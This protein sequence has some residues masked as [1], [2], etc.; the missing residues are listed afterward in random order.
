M[1]SSGRESNPTT[2]TRRRRT[3]SVCRRST[4]SFSN[5]RNVG[6]SEWTVRFFRWFTFKRS[7]ALCTAAMAL[8]GVVTY[9]D[10]EGWLQIG[11][12]PGKVE[13]TLGRETT[14]VVQ[15]L[16]PDGVVDYMGAINA[17]FA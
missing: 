8:Y 6:R 10:A 2:R 1:E 5:C 7:L 13:I 14:F 17:H 12:N 16:R 4:T 11:Q 9:T 15:P 3:E